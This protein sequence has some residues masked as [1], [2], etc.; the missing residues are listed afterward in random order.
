L[1]IIGLFELGVIPSNKA[2]FYCNDA[3]LAFPFRGDTVTTSILMSGLLLMP[4][5]VFLLTEFVFTSSDSTKSKFLQTLKNSCWLYRCYVYG[6][7]MNLCIIEMDSYRSFP[8]GHTSMS[9]YCGFF[10]AWY[11]QARAFNWRHRSVLLVPFLQLGALSFA[12]VSSLTR[13]TD[14]RHHWWDVLTGSA[15]GLI[16]LLYAVMVPASALVPFLQHVALS[17]AVVSSLNRITDRRHHWWD[18][19]TGSAI[20]LIT[21][22]YAVMV[23]ASALVPFLQHVALSFAVVSSLNRITDR[24]HHWWD[25]LTGS[26]IGLITLLYAVSPLQDN[27]RITHSFVGFCTQRVPTGPSTGLLLE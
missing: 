25:V 23:P 24:R 8:S 21:L 19:L 11:L 7:M 4:I 17:F 10:V 14:R 15:I 1:S 5:F 6:L 13:I 26:A 18:M 2:G 9:V 27:L 20:G 3:A 22:L 12:V 16:T